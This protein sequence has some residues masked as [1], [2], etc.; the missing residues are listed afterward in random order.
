MNEIYMYGTIDTAM[1]SQVVEALSAK[2]GDL[3]IRLNSVGG[4]VFAAMSIYNLLKEYKGKVEVVVDGLCASAAT[5][6]LCAA[7]KVTASKAS[8]LFFHLPSRLFVDFYNEAD[9]AKEQESL[10]KMREVI[11]DTYKT[12]SS[13]SE[14]DLNNLMLSETWLKAE[15][16]QRLG[17]VDEVTNEVVVNIFKP[18][19]KDNIL[20]KFIARIAAKLKKAE[21]PEPKAPEKTEEQIAAEY[22]AQ[23]LKDNFESGA[24]KVIGSTEMKSERVRQAELIAK[25][26]NRN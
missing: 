17:F 21:P 6:I 10:A 25:F 23:M 5:I 2:T 15:Q 7:D 11:T 14:E 9:L 16:A 3:K 8:L 12:K 18:P 1:S 24:D 22:F 26:A 4:E 20:D 19:A 13:L